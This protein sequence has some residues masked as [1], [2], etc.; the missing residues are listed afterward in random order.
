MANE[1]TISGSL[2]WNE[3]ESLLAVEALLVSMTGTRYF[4][5]IQSIGITEEAIQLGELSGNTLGWALFINL[6]ST[7]YLELRSGTGAS[8]DIIKIKAGE[9]ALFRFGS[10]VTAP[11]ALANT[12]ACRMKY[13]IYEA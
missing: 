5:G 1:L 7:N 10:D 6:D 3:D 11:Y 12:A 8:N 13:R 4:G 9:F 2:T